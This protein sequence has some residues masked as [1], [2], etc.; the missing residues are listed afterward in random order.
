MKITFS[1]QGTISQEISMLDESISSEALQKGLISGK[2]ATTIQEGS[3]F[4]EEISTGKRIADILSIDNNLEYF[5]YEVE[6]N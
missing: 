5:D 4:V 6:D 3:T 2:Y 1:A